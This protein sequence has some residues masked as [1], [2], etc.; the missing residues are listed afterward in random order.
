[1]IYPL[2]SSIYLLKQPGQDCKDRSGLQSIKFDIVI[3][4]E[5][6]KTAIIVKFLTF[7]AATLSL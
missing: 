7:L 5:E 3:G 6:I 1:M 2:E 4:G